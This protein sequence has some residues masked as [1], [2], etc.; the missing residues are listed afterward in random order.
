MKYT[1]FLLMALLPP[2]LF[3]QN[4]VPA[5]A[6]LPLRLDTSLN[7]HRIWAG[8]VIRAELMQD[9][10]GTAVHKGS[11][12]VGRVVSVAPGRIGLRFD[13]LVVKKQTIPLT[14]NLRALA[15]M[16]EVEDAQIPEDGADRALSSPLDQ[17]TRQIGGEQVYR[18][19]G[20]VARGITTVGEPTAYGVLGRLNSNSPCRG[21]SQ[22]DDTPQ[23]LWLFSTDACGLYGF[24]DL[25][26]EHYGR[27]APIGT[28]VLASKTGKMNIR[29]GSGIL[30]RVDG[31]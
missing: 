30:L 14:T 13:T 18:G 1:W 27:T 29:T 17:T 3:G 24:S 21:A 25:T 9:I 6:V 12:V 28:I 5:G 7:T 2:V 19:G 26:I 4:T 22:E 11:H 20:P 15:S 8:K 16:L 23:A 31:P 10:P